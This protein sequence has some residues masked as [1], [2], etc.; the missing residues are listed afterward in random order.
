MTA[1]AHGPHSPAAAVRFRRW[2]AA[3]C[4]LCPPLRKA[5]TPHREPRHAAAVRAGRCCEHQRCTSDGMG[6]GREVLPALQRRHTT[7]SQRLSLGARAQGLQRARQGSPAAA[8]AGLAHKQ[9]TR[10]VSLWLMAPARAHISHILKNGLN[11]RS[12]GIF[13]GI[14]RS[15]GTAVH[16][17]GS[18]VT[19]RN[20]TRHVHGRKKKTPNPGVLRPY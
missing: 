17:T 20:I 13:W 19:F 11:V 10:G 18:G 5:A 1:A 2:P 9:S 16:N 15:G 14:T 6:G 3:P 12:G 7:E 4:R 8:A